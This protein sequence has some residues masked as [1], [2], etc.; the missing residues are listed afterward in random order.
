MNEWFYHPGCFIIRRML[1]VTGGVDVR[2][3]DHIPRDGPFIVVANHASLWDPPILG[4]ATGYQVNRTVHF[5]AKQ[6]MHEWPVI[7]WLAD[8]SGVYFVRRGEG[9]RAAHRMSL[10]LLAAGK[11]IAIFP[12][13]TRSRDGRMR[14]GK[15]GASLI[16]MRSGAPILPVGIAGTHRLFPRGTHIPHRSPVTV[17]IGRLFTLE[18]RPKGRLERQALTAGTDVIMREIAALVPERQRGDYRSI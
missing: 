14:A 5:M 8:Q 11:P 4:W 10:E 3:R 6:E 7:G 18:H 13:G 12:D 16:A 1:D 9:D 17:Q 2:G 15:D